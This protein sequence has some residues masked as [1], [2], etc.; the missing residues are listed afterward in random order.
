[1][2]GVV[3]FYQIE[4]PGATDPGPG[5]LFVME[6][7]LNVEGTLGGLDPGVAVASNDAWLVGF[8]FYEDHVISL[9]ENAASA[10]FFPGVY[11]QYRLESSLS[12]FPPVIVIQ[13]AGTFKFYALDGSAPG[14]I[15][16]ITVSENVTGT[17]HH[18]VVRDTGGLG[19]TSVKEI[20][21]P[22]P[23]GPYCTMS[24]SFL[25]AI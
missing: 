18:Y 9:F 24:R 14:I 25:S 13:S 6:W 16:S 23:S 17:V 2:T 21:R 10:S 19:A 12:Q 7:R 5:E 3:D 20:D 11:H 15:D 22:M 1:M 4:R 8:N